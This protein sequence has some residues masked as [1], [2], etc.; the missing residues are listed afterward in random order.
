MSEVMQGFRLYYTRALLCPAGWGVA[1]VDK[2]KATAAMNSND[3]RPYLLSVAHAGQ[4][5]SPE[6]DIMCACLTVIACLL[7]VQPPSRRELGTPP[8]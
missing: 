8:S 3:R 2:V 7:L 4:G 5:T 6:S 1:L